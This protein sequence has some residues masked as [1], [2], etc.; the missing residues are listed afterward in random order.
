MKIAKI[1]ILA[2][3]KRGNQRQQKRK[4]VRDVFGLLTVVANL[5]LF[6]IYEK[7]SFGGMGNNRR[8]NL[9]PLM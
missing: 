2:E 6:P 9:T 3:G 5:I 4:S 7:G 1:Y 8:I